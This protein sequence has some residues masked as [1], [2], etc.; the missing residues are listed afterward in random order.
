MVFRFT[1]SLI[2]IQLSLFL[3]NCSSFLTRHTFC[4]LD[5]SPS[6]TNLTVPQPKPRT[7]KPQAPVPTPRQRKPSVTSQL[8]EDNTNNQPLS[9]NEK[10]IQPVVAE[11]P[12]SP[13]KMRRQSKFDTIGRKRGFQIGKS[14][15][16]MEAARFVDDNSSLHSRKVSG[17]SSEKTRT[18]SS[19]SSQY[20]ETEDNLDDLDINNIEMFENTHR[21]RSVKRKSKE[22]FNRIGS[23]VEI[24][25]LPASASYKQINAELPSNESMLSLRSV[26]SMPGFL[27]SA[28][29]MKKWDSMQD[30]DEI[31]FCA[32]ARNRAWLVGDVS[33]TG[34]FYT[35]LLTLFSIS[36]H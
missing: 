24:H 33:D 9:G 2:S 19:S 29:N 25:E 36:L 21:K 31:S 3:T 22:T 4:M 34:M 8:S 17:S 30:L 12:N 27:G 14:M 1:L 6:L 32:E 35:K 7:I 5:V 28:A 26:D 16:S 13:E 20:F 23:N 18:T 11:L 15:L 10:D